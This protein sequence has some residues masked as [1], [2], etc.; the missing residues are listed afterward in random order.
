M[1]TATG[2][3]GVVIVAFNA[4]SVIRDC[5]HSLYQSRGPQ[6]KIVIVDNASTDDTR[7]VIR[8]WASTIPEFAE[9]SSHQEASTPVEAADY[10]LVCAA[11]NAGFAAGVNI[12][13]RHL[14]SQP[15]IDLFWILNPDIRV[16]PDA[17]ECFARRAG[18]VGTFSLM[19]GR[20]LYINPKDTIQSDGGHLNT[21][22]GMCASAN[23]GRPASD[24][25]YPS[26][27][28]FDYIPGANIVASRAFIDSVGLMDESYFL[29]YE[30]VDW[31]SRRG[32]L[33]LAYA[34]GAIV[35]HH[36]GSAIGSPTL[37]KTQGTSFAN[38]FNYRSRMRF[39]RRFFPWR[40][41]V[42][43][44]YSILK[45]VRLA[46]QGFYEEADGAFRGLHD[47]PPPTNV[48]RRLTEEAARIAFEE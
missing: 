3:I 32:A 29:Y 1:E 41:P 9:M 20:T 2:T 23:L 15:D 11:I 12:G 19:G 48:R 10:L 21:W 8:H 13:L 24:T 7:D 39:M 4:E 27:S 35:E 25:S 6:L 5:L 42:V 14:R 18:E 43:Y 46:M 36:G 28:Q 38:Y 34:P 17:A 44:I 30:E 40:L 31:A 47:L 22:T 45:V 16:R 37:G 26:A 33:S